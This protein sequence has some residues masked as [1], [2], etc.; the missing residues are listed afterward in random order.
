MACTL[1]SAQV[2]SQTSWGFLV[3][4]FAVTVN[5]QGFGTLPLNL[6][7]SLS[8]KNSFVQNFWSN[9]GMTSSVSG[10]S[11]AFTGSLW[12]TQI[13]LGGFIRNDTSLNI[14]ENPLASMTV[15]GIPCK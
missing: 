13:T 10:S 4:Q 8:M 2:T 5:L 14:G 12:G 1:V 6:N 11:G 9:F 7:G 15:N 3:N